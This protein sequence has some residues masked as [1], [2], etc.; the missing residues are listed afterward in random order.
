MT[1]DHPDKER[2]SDWLVENP[3]IIVIVGSGFALVIFFLLYLWLQY[4][5]SILT[6][7]PH[8]LIIDKFAQLSIKPKTEV[9]LG[10]TSTLS[11]EL[12]P[13]EELAQT[14]TVHCKVVEYSS[15]VNITKNPTYTKTFNPTDTDFGAEPWDV[16]FEVDHPSEKMQKISFYVTLTVETF[17]AGNTEEL[18]REQSFDIKTRSPRNSLWARNGLITS[19]LLFVIS[20]FW[21]TLT[22]Y[23]PLI[24]SN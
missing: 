6:D 1:I 17:V 11:L 15:Y 2:I 13:Y 22:Q 20:F 24:H 10:S 8:T 7:K 16:D 18:D 9:V 21:K 4:E 19:C 5:P 23:F 3:R 14:I 12:I